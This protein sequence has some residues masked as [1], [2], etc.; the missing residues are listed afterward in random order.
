M[1]ICDWVGDALLLLL[2]LKDFLLNSFV[3]VLSSCHEEFINEA[4][5]MWSASTQICRA[6]NSNTMQRVPW[7]GLFLAGVGAACGVGVL[8]TNLF[9]V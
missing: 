4:L 6:L 5:H 3:D 1:V 7:I 9:P 2:L 8:E